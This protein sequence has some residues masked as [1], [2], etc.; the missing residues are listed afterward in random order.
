MAK[1]ANLPTRLAPMHR[2]N[3]ELYVSHT[4]SWCQ[5]FELTAS[6]TPFRTSDIY[7]FKGPVDEDGYIAISHPM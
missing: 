1:G 5:A 3:Y 4:M 2:L 7:S 6:L